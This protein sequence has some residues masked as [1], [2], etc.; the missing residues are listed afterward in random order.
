MFS[1]KIE[2]TKHFTALGLLFVGV[3]GW[4]NDIPRIGIRTAAPPM[5]RSALNRLL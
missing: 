1:L 4:R 3:D 5:Y 2:K